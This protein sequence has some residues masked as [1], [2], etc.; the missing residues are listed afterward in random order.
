MTTGET[1]VNGLVVNCDGEP[2]VP[3]G[4]KIGEHK[5]RN[6]FLW[7][8][9]CIVFR[10]MMDLIHVK[11]WDRKSPNALYDELVINPVCNINVLEFLESNPKRI[12]KEFERKWIF[13]LDTTYIRYDDSDRYVCY[14]RNSGS[15]SHNIIWWCGVPHQHYYV[16]LYAD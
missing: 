5:P 3:L 1:T 9:D 13:F 12:P 2:F 16:A 8:P 14:L 11:N 4:Y 15:W 7:S 6:K 10:P